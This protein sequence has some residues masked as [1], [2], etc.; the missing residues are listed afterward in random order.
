MLRRP[1]TVQVEQLV[2]V[3]LNIREVLLSIVCL[4]ILRAETAMPCIT[5]Y[6]DMLLVVEQQLTTGGDG[7]SLGTNL[8][9]DRIR[10][11]RVPYEQAILHRLV[12]VYA[13]ID[14]FI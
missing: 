12:L 4:F 5:V 8:P 7:I 2:V 9:V 13:S 1:L 10:D 14:L 11:H 3:V 6:E